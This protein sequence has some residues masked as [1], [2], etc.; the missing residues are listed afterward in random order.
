MLS[1]VGTFTCGTCR[2]PADSSGNNKESDNCCQNAEEGNV[3][4]I[5]CII[6]HAAVQS[7]AYGT[8]TGNHT[9]IPV[10][11][12]QIRNHVAR[13]DTFTDG[14]GQVSF[15]SIT[16]IE[17][18]AA[19]VGHQKNDQTIILSFL[20]HTPFIEQAVCKVKAIIIADGR[21][22]GNYCLNAGLLFQC[23]QHTVDAVAGSLREDAVRIADIAHFVLKMYFGDIVCSIDLL[24]LH[25]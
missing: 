3:F 10:T 24:C 11:I 16:S 23:I 19:L 7:A 8:H 21:N 12:F 1:A 20:S 18:D 17:L 5:I 13:L 4:F 9:C 6:H 14:I 2:H 25:G 22:Y 15:Q